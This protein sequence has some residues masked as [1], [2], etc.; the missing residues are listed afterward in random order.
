MQHVLGRERDFDRASRR[1]VELVDLVLAVEVL[2]LPHPAF[3]CRVNLQRLI[4]RPH[5][6]EEDVRGPGE[7]HD[8]DEEGDDRPGQLEGDGTVDARAHLQRILGAV[9]R[10]EVDDH[11]GGQNAEERRYGEDEEVQLIDICRER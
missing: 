8:G 9:L 7:D 10:S 3:T 4:R 1:N 11:D 2:E 6:V 5:E